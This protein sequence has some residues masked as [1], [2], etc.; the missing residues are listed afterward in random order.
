MT[1]RRLRALLMVLVTALALSACG[2]GGA[3]QVPTTPPPPTAEPTD[4]PK[5]TEKPTATAK[6]TAEPTEKP[7]AEPTEKPTAEPTAD[8]KPTT[9][10]LVS[11][12]IEFGE[13]TTFSHPKGVFSIDYPKNWKVEDKSNATSAMVLF[14]DPTGNGIVI[15][16]VTETA[17]KLDDAAL[18][19]QMNDF[20]KQILSDVKNLKIEKAVP[21]KDGSLRVDFTYDAESEGKKL[22]FQGG[23]F[24]EQREKLLS[25]LIDGAPAEQW[26][27]IVGDFDKVINTYKLDTTASLSG[28]GGTSGTALA[29]V[30]VGDLK[31]F[32]YKG[33]LFTIDAPTAWTEEDK[34]SKGEALVTWTDESRN[35]QVVVDV[36]KKPSTDLT[37]FLNKFLTDTYKQ[38]TNFKAEKAVP[39]SDGSVLVVFSYDVTVQG[40]DVTLTGNSFIQAHG[41]KASILS[42]LVPSDQFKTLEPDT[43]KIINSYKVDE[44]AALP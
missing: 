8:T 20:L 31:T 5:P 3:A 37:E 32:E 41:D 6:P 39:Q 13:L 2:L 27:S 44:T 23:A 24:V 19:Q 29:D 25:F 10:G 35:A 36:F 17:D 9:E 38:A 34:S 12:K 11:Q 14:T 42:T 16:R 21:Q 15:T 18:E 30:K 26:E 4:E 1:L 28:T 7:T 43:N 22:L 40:L 33:G